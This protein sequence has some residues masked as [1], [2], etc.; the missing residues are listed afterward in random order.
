VL[1]SFANKEDG[2]AKTLFIRLSTIGF[3]PIMLRTQYR[4]ITCLTEP[5]HQLEALTCKR[6]VLCTLQCHPAISGIAN[7]LFYEGKL[8]DG[9]TPE[10]RS[11]LLP[12][13]PTL[14][15]CNSLRGTVYSSFSS[16]QTTVC[17]TRNS[18][19]LQEERAGKSYH[20][21][22]EL[23]LI[24][25]MVKSLINWGIKPQQIGIIALCTSAA[26]QHCVT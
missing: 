6:L 22:Y 14:Y 25:E 18:R 13:L 1:E 11:P 9:V 20:N 3:P 4:V 21:P 15:F 5:P 7:R 17:V 8:L 2:L 10:Q 12:T 19:G 26:K 24:V 23:G 16:T